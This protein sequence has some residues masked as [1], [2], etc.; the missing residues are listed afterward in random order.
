M[1]GWLWKLV[2][3]NSGVYIIK[4][5][6]NIFKSY[7]IKLKKKKLKQIKKTK[8]MIKKKNRN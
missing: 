4:K 2:V 7:T 6:K 3:K 8:K 1:G 5:I